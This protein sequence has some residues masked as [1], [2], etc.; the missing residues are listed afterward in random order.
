MTKGIDIE[1]VEQRLRGM[2]TAPLPEFYHRRIVFWH[3]EDEQYKDVIKDIVLPDVKV[4]VLTPTNNFVLKKL[5]AHDDLL[6]NYLIYTNVE[7]REDEENWLFNIELYSEQFH[8]NRIS[9]WMDEMGITESLELRKSI[10]RYKKFFESKERRNK[11]ADLNYDITSEAQLHLSVMT[12]L[13]D[14]KEVNPNIILREVFT[15]G[16]EESINPVYNK[17]VQF[18]AD[19]AFWAFVQKY[20]GYSSSTN[21][22][23]LACHILLTA[24][25]RTMREEHF[26]GLERYIS[27]PHQSYC[28]DFISEWLNSNDGV[29]YLYDLAEEVQEW[30]QL[31]SRFDK[32]S[33]DDLA[34]TACFPCINES[35]LIKLM[36][37]ILVGILPVTQIKALIE[38]R[39][40]FA[41]YDKTQYYFDG[42]M[43]VCNMQEFETVN[44]HKLHIADPTELWNCYT[45]YYY[46][47]DTYYRQ[48]HLCYQNSLKQINFKLEELFKKV[49][50]WVENLYTQGYLNKLAE[51]WTNAVAQDMEKTGK[52]PGISFQE[53]FYASRIKPSANRV[54]VIISDALRYEVGVSLAKQLKK[55]TKSEVEIKSCQA[56]FPTV[57]KFGMAAL[58][59]HNKLTVE[60]RLSGE[61]Q[62]LADGNP[63]D[64][65]YRD[66]ILK[67]ANPQ[68]IALKFKDIIAM[69]RQERS[70]RVK[71]MKVVYIYHDKID[72]ASHISDSEVFP[73]CDRAIDEIKN[74]V[75][76]IANDFGGTRIIITADHGF[77]YTYNPL[78][79]DSKIDKTTS[80]LEDVEVERRYIIKKKGKKPEYLLPVKFMNGD[81]DYEI[82]TPREN[83]RIK[84]KGG[85]V[86]FVHGGLSL[87]EMVVPII[88]YH[89]LRNNSSEYK[90][91]RALYDVRPVQLGLYS[92]ARKI[93]NLIFSLNFYQKEA[94]GDNWRAATYLLYFV[95]SANIKISDTQKIIADKTAK[96]SNGRTFRCTF[97]LK[98]QKYSKTNLYYLVI[99]EE[100]GV[101]M[102]VKEEFQ[103]DIAL[104]VD[105]FDFRIGDGDEDGN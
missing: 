81:T 3:D 92:A 37:N 24:A 43:Q 11:I 67:K 20:T 36:N 50:G 80:S 102:P 45:S 76:I 65:G 71:E 72:E 54:F 88:E 61:V 2:F 90:K 14:K 33:E 48:F 38:K 83:V 58:L 30:L 93:Y 82:Y 63:T 44:V 91:N 89:F 34:D 100:S 1:S 23:D 40:T 105:G 64:A 99:Q 22:S 26:A 74:L 6:S 8:A 60:P 10:K 25:T 27:T 103:I 73:A 96:E 47:M 70:A 18:G 86:N 97:N 4:F 28:Y 75:R 59:P 15:Q 104:S 29:E 57:T 12:V 55:E 7:Y 39:R 56:I 35:I 21:L 49:M 77:L 13:C 69:S 94:V 17:F 84:K 46:V 78:N 85:S 41:W 16:T 31:G 62:V 5:L 79:E 68:S 19:K 42:I 53:N 52:V 87:Q 66:K 32:L 95:D 98:T 101:E 51:S 9:S